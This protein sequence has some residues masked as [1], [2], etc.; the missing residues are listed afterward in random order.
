MLVIDENYDIMRRLSDDEFP[1]VVS[2][3]LGDEKRMIVYSDKEK[4]TYK[5]LIEIF[6]KEGFLPKEAADL[7][8]EDIRTSSLLV[9]GYQSPVLKRLFG[10]V[11]DPGPGF[12]MTVRNNPLN[13]AKV[14]A[15]ANAPSG[16]EV[17]LA[18]SKIFHY[19]KYST[20]RFE[21]GRNTSKETAETER[22]MVFDFAK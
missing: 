19:G 10:Y 13:K 7:K 17:S 8:D 22:G 5:D 16:E 3:L 14:V 21:R 9:L 1:P 11:K 6:R 2:R 4:D 15:Y 20:I 18:A 12:A